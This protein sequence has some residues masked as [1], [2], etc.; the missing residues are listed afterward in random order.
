MGPLVTEE[1]LNRVLGYVEA[2]RKEGAKV[3]V[4]GGRPGTQAKGY[5]MEPTLVSRRESRDEDRAGGDLTGLSPPCCRSGRPREALAIAN[6]TIYGL[7]ASI[8]T[9]D[10]STAHKMARA[11]QAGIVW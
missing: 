10:V 11:V 9:R 7:A 8:W 4:G 1:Q 6:G 2:G 3:V 5:Y